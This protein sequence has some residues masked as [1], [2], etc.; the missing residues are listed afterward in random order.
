MADQVISSDGL[1][2][3]IVPEIWSA[4]YQTNLRATTPFLSLIASDYEGEIS[5]LGDTVR[6]PT[7]ADGAV[8]N[9][10][11]E[12]AAGDASTVTVSTTSLVVNT[13]LYKDF[14][15]TDKAQLQSIDS[16]SMLQDNAIFA[17]Q[18]KFHQN[19]IA[20]IVP[21]AA[22]PDHTIGYDSSTTLG[23]ADLL[24]VLDLEKAANWQGQKYFVTGG[25]QY[26][27]IV[28]LDKFANKD[29][30]DG[31]APSVTGVI[32]S[33]IYG[34]GFMQS[35]DCGT[36]TSAFMPSFMQSAVQKSIQIEVVRQG[37]DGKRSWRVNVDNLVG[38]V[39]VNNTRVITLS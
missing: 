25:A 14:I 23:D 4:T 13:M 18:H 33:N 21:S 1:F 8:A 24:E 16:M 29:T 19:I 6:I 37:A 20:A 11:T 38:I 27:D 15:I 2:T 32:T 28:G 17:I 22:S 39:Q 30:N 9:D 36:T 10:L 7:M 3:A 31:S 5:S 26:N 34:H 12:G 35:G